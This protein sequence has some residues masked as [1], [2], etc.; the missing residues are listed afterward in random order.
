MHTL[1]GR[2]GGKWEVGIGGIIFCN[3]DTCTALLNI[4]FV[5]IMVREKLHVGIETTYVK[6]VSSLLDLV[7]SFF[8]PFWSATFFLTRAATR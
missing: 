6:D 1:C 7:N 2:G 8:R 4:F 3:T 5:S